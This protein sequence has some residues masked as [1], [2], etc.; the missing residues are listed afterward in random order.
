MAS[1]SINNIDRQ[2]YEE[3][4]VTADIRG[5]SIEDLACRILTKALEQNK[6]TDGLGTRIHKRFS[7]DGGVE[8]DLPSR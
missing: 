2:L 7:L 3:L 6:C 1:L 5:L 8:L 4:R